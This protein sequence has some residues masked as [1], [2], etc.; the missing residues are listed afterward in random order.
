M[1][2]HATARTMIRKTTNLRR[3][4]LEILA[5][6]TLLTG[7]VNATAQDGVPDNPHWNG[8]GCPACHAPGNPSAANLL[9]VS[10]G[11]SATCDGC[12]GDRGSAVACRHQSGLDPAG[13]SISASYEPHLDNG[14]VVCTT[15]HDLSVQCL[16]PKRSASYM[17]PGF[18]RDR[19]SR[20]SGEQCFQCHEKAGYQKLNAHAIIA[21]DPAQPTCLL[22][23]ER[24][25][26]TDEA[27]E[28]RL[29]FNMRDDLNDTCRGCHNVRPHPRGMTFTPQDDSWNHLVVP[30]DD[31]RRNMEVAFEETGTRLPLDPQSGEIFCGTCHNQHKFKFG[32]D[33]ASLQRATDKRL[34]S[35]DICQACHAK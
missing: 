31:I 27:G 5:A 33:D 3:M 32:G 7:S 19:V 13:M 14:K 23:H 8:D 22:C 12:H 34:R 16:S 20:Q 30:P 25:P 11:A 9:L 2:C 4:T 10:E 26:E 24:L 6:V 1:I 17:N 18:L 15:C 21:G 28:I 35:G 29:A